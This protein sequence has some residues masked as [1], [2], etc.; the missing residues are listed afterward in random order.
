[1]HFHDLYPSACC[2]H[3]FYIIIY[4]W[5]LK[6][7]CKSQTGVLLRKLTFLLR[8]LSNFNQWRSVPN[9]QAGQAYAIMFLMGDLWNDNLKLVPNRLSWNR[10]YT[11]THVLKALALI[12]SVCNL[13]ILILS[14]TIPSHITQFANIIFRPVIVRRGSGSPRVSKK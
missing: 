4:I 13:D 12:I 5:N 14:K 7:I 2:L 10:E 3:T 9:L 11:S 1:M 6:A 8:N